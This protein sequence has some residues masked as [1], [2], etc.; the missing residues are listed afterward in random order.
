[1]TA[2]FKIGDLVNWTTDGGTVICKIVAVSQSHRKRGGH[3][4]PRY[5][6]AD[7]NETTYIVGPKA[8]TP[9]KD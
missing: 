1:M 5:T 4:R 9:Y 8:L 7:A 2:F 3:W 6:I